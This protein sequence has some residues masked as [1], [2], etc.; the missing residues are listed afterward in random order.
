MSF[1]LFTGVSFVIN[2]LLNKCCLTLYFRRVYLL[3]P[4]VSALAVFASGWRVIASYL[5]ELLGGGEVANHSLVLGGG[6]RVLAY[7]FFCLFFF[8]YISFI[9]R[10]LS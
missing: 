10:H 2:F 6:E 1:S 9:L 4:V 7:C 8:I 3:I 5:L